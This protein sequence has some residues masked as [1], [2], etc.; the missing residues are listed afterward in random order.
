[1]VSSLPGSST[2][3]ILQA[4]ILEW[5]AIPFSWGIFPTQ[6]LNPGHL[7]CQQILYQLSHQESPKLFLILIIIFND[8]KTCSNALSFTVDI[9]NFYVLFFLIIILKGYQLYQISIDILKKLVFDLTDFLLF[10]HFFS[11]ISIYHFLPFTYF[12]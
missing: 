9:Y 1:M 5:V 2:H 10:I 7:H 8:H 11:L 6:E 3:G 4:R 12:R